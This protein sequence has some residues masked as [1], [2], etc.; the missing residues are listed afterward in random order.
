MKLNILKLLNCTEKLSNNK[1][2]T[3][4]L[5]TYI[6]TQKVLLLGEL[7]I[8]TIH[9]QVFKTNGISKGKNPSL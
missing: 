7:E 5:N 1:F 2:T 4:N 9:M 8:S 3:I 6:K